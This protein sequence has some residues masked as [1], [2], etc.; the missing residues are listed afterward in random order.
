MVG[1]GHHVDLPAHP[2]IVSLKAMLKDD[3]A[4][5]LV[6]EIYEGGELFYYIIIRGHFLEKGVAILTHTIMKVIYT[7]N[8]HKI[9]HGNLRL[10]NFLLMIKN[11]NL[12]LW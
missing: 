8:T 5:H 1:S 3:K 2:N 7:C 6:M 11:S 4:L 10:K 12:P 9:M